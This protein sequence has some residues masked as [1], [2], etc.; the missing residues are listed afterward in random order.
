VRLG[1]TFTLYPV[2]DEGARPFLRA[3]GEGNFEHLAFSRYYRRIA[4]AIGR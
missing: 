1:I 4:P 2:T 3:E